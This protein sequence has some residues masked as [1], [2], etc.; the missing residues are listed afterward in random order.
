MIEQYSRS[1]GFFTRK[2]TYQPGDPIQPGISYFT[3]DPSEHALSIAST[4]ETVVLDSS[5]DFVSHW[6]E[7]S[8]ASLMWNAKYGTANILV[9]EVGYGVTGSGTTMVG[10]FTSDLTGLLVADALDNAHVFPVNPGGQ[11]VR[12]LVPWPHV[13]SCG[14]MT[15]PGS[16]R[17]LS[18]EQREA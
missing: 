15:P 5:S 17:C 8:R 10:R 9:P 18:C 11:A 14:A 4:G 1:T 16:R 3:Y 12:D 6:L 2:H 7:S 13:C